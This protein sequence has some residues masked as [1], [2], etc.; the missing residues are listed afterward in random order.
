MYILYIAWCIFH[1]RYI[2]ATVINNGKINLFDTQL[3]WLFIWNHANKK[4]QI[5]YDHT[6]RVT[7][8]FILV[9]YCISSKAQWLF[10]SNMNNEYAHHIYAKKYR[11]V[12]P[13]MDYTINIITNCDFV[14]AEDMCGQT[15]RSSTFMIFFS[16]NKPYGLQSIKW[17][18][19]DFDT[20]TETPHKNFKK[21]TGLIWKKKKKK[22]PS[23]VWT[24][25]CQKIE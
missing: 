13:W 3:R 4:K 19:A 2:V 16:T 21:E 10:L 18:T 1:H 15:N 22:K 6:S 5:R 17:N 9:F 11:C 24:W 12:V 14:T 25:W 8:E 20:F 23:K 7:T